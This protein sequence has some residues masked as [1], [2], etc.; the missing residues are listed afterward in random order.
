[1]RWYYLSL[2][3]TKDSWFGTFEELVMSLFKP[4]GVI[5]LCYVET[6]AHLH[7]PPSPTYFMSWFSF[8]IGQS[9]SRDRAKTDLQ[10]FFS[11]WQPIK[12]AIYHAGSQ[13]MI[14]AFF[15]MWSST[16]QFRW[17]PSQNF[18]SFW[19]EWLWQGWYLKLIARRK[20]HEV[21]NPW[22]QLTVVKYHPCAEPEFQIN[23]LKWRPV[24]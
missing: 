11:N 20:S 23:G 21:C 17:Q 16:P 19:A 4:L 15:S 12:S 8:T 22:D 18:G 3:L 10:S 24:C 1:M 13:K 6:R 2:V 5:R 14:L 7:W 9:F